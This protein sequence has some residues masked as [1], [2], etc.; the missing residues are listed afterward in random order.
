MNWLIFT[1]L[2]ILWGAMCFLTSWAFV[3]LGGL[4]VAWAIVRINRFEI[5]E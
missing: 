4:V 5:K 1:L 3:S 2:G